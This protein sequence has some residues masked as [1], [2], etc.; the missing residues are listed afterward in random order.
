MG[1]F[2]RVIF[3]VLKTEKIN[4]EA[5]LDNNSHFNNK[6]CYGIKIINFNKKTQKYIKKLINP[7]IIVSHQDIKVIKKIN[8]DLR[9]Y[10]LKRS[11]IRVMNWSTIL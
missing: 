11:N 9:K 2:G 4:I 6:K 3:Q 7:L 10:G 5:F 8:N 1:V